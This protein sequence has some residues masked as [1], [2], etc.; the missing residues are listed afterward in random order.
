[1]ANLQADQVKGHFALYAVFQVEFAVSELE[2]YVQA[3]FNA[4]FHF[5]WRILN[6][7]ILQVLDEKLLFFCYFCVLTDDC[8]EHIVAD[9]NH[10]SIVGL[11]LL[12]SFSELKGIAHVVGE[13]AWRL[14]ISDELQESAGLFSVNQ[15]LQLADQL[16]PDALMIK[17]LPLA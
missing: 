2:F 7:L 16:D 9:S 12:F 14:Q 5:D 4:N 13:R 6:R 10:D 8:D 3:V 15:I 11:K 1:M 17:L